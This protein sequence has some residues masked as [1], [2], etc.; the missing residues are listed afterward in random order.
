MNSYRVTDAVIY[1]EQ[2]LKAT[3]YNLLS[4]ISKQVDI[5]LS[6]S[7]I[8]DANFLANLKKTSQTKTNLGQRKL[9]KLSTLQQA[10]FNDCGIFAFR[11]S[12]FG[13]K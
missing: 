13:Y 8:I 4:I 11:K 6:L 3:F 2:L 12:F 1:D 5:T 9:L 7:W 10:H